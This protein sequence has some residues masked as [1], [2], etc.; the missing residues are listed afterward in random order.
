ME[1]KKS[2]FKLSAVGEALAVAGKDA[3]ATQKAVINRGI[4]KVDLKDPLA[5]LSLLDGTVYVV[6][7]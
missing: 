4:H 6:T 5:D 7:K 1:T 2:E 3:K